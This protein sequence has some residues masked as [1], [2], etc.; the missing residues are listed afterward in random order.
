LPAG[1]SK[2]QNGAMLDWNDIR[3]F[4]AVADSG[5]TLAAGRLLRVSQTTAARRVAALEAALG[6][7]LF[8]RRQA[9]YQLTE[10]GAALLDK[11]RAVEA[12]ASGFTDAAAAEARSVSGAVRLT[13]IEIYALTLLPPILRDLHDA[14]PAIRIELDTSDAV[15]DLAAGEADIA[16]RNSKSPQGGGLVGRRIAD[17][18]WTV[19]CSRAYAAAHRRPRTREDLKGHAFVGGGGPGV[20]RAYR[21]WLERYGLEEAVAMQQ[22]STTGMLAAVRAGIGLAVLPCFLAD[23][24]PDLVRVLP[25]ETAS[26]SGIWLLTHERVRHAPRVR[27]VIDFIADRL[28]RLARAAPLAISADW[29]A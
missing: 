29:A 16:L 27:T 8:E 23:R 10:A 3:A 2:V 21:A 12:A 11:A 5:S 19:Y 22:D 4:I 6:L 14:W 1:S 24:E 26:T 20:W 28:T 18:P 9:G 13:A 17:D 15:R 7:T 25:P